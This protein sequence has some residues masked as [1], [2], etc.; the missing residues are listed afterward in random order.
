MI[1]PYAINDLADLV[2]TQDIHF[3]V[4]HPKVLE[5]T[6]AKIAEKHFDINQ[7]SKLA[8]VL[9]STPLM[10][11]SLLEKFLL[12]LEGTIGLESKDFVVECILKNSNT[13]SHLL[14]QYSTHQKKSLRSCVA[15]N[16]GTPTAI[17]EKLATDVETWVRE[18]VAKNEKAP[19]SLLEKLAKD[20][21]K[22][23]RSG[24][25]RN[26]SI[27]TALL[28]Q[29]FRDNR[30]CGSV[31]DSI[32]SNLNTPVA[33]VE[34]LISNPPPLAHLTHLAL[35]KREDLSSLQL[36]VILEIY[37]QRAPF[38]GAETYSGHNEREIISAICIHPNA[39]ISSLEKLLQCAVSQFALVRDKELLTN[40]ANNA[41]QTPEA[42]YESSRQFAQCVDT[43]LRR[44]GADENNQNLKQ[45]SRHLG[46]QLW[47]AAYGSH[48]YSG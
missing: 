32:A 14:E 29:V 48:S 24:L 5:S 9:C 8:F 46:S 44:R 26:R 25:A 11:S 43:A 45:L 6:V 17:L 40:Q 16:P 3:I 28:E 4:E 34:E 31:C 42:Y 27:P 36:D 41:G 30:D 38:P 35:A 47:D 37:L 10:P 21:K 2:S 1:S 33:I 23:V 20:E 13:P 12:H 15:V 18:S 7:E 39:S 22:E 19:L